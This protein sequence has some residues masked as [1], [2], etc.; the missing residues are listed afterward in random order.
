M[1]ITKLFLLIFVYSNIHLACMY[2]L[3]KQIIAFIFLLIVTVPLLF[4]IKFIIKE[5]LLHKA[6]EEKMKSVHLQTI[7]IAKKDLV[8]I[9]AGKEILVNDKF[10]D[11]KKYH[12]K[13]GM[14]I[15]TG[16]FDEEETMI[17]SIHKKNTEK[18]NQDNPISKSAFKFLFSTDLKSH[19]EI[20]HERNWKLIAKHWF[21]FDERLLLMIYSQK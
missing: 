7:H 3:H 6:V 9:R 8:W 11:V 17:I 2:K 13:E 18:D 5:S 10:F 15:L 14:V 12:T 19:I 4:S 20:I 21:V 16:Y 1:S